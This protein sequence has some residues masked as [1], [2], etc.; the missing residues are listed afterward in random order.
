MEGYEFHQVDYLDVPVQL[1]LH[2]AA[3]SY[4][5]WQVRFCWCGRGFSAATYARL[6]IRWRATPTAYPLRS[7][8]RA[9]WR[10]S[11]DITLP[12]GH[13]VDETPDPVSVNVRFASYRSS[14][15][16]RCNVLHYEREYVVRQAEIPAEKADD[17]RKVEGTIAFDE[18][19]AV[20]LK[21]IDRAPAN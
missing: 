11:F 18:K 12:A 6:P 13:T 8:I 5:P 21:R 16:A 10:D 7:A 17:F 3:A 14:I 1:D 20:M 15:A 4:G 19:G 9:R 2:V